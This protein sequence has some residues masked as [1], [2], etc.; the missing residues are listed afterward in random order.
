M[1]FADTAP[2]RE[3]REALGQRFRMGVVAYLGD[4]VEVLDRS[5]CLVPVGA[6]LGA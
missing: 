4:S 1:T 3:L 2:L 5:L 6:L